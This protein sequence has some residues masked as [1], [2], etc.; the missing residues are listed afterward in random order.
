MATSNA[1]LYAGGE[2]DFC[3]INPDTLQLDLAEVQDKIAGAALVPVRELFP[4][5]LQ[6]YPLPWMDLNP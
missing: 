2:V 5:I 3:D 4:L 6:D 1:I